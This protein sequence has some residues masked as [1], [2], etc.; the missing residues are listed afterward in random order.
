MLHLPDLRNFPQAD[1][2]MHVC[3]IIRGDWFRKQLRSLAHANILDCHGVQTW[4][5]GDGCQTVSVARMRVTV[6]GYIFHDACIQYR[7]L[8][9]LSGDHGLGHGIHIIG[10][11]RETLAQKA[12]PHR[13]RTHS[14]GASVRVLAYGRVKLWRAFGRFFPRWP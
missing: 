2:N 9:C 10:S 14:V 5:S 8:P 3:I 4:H 13:P 11:Q 12:R 1:T 7:L 6:T